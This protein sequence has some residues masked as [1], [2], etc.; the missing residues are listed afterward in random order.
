MTSFR[1][2]MAVAAGALATL[3]TY[4]LR[5]NE[6]FAAEW[7]PTSQLEMIISAKAGSGL[8]NT[9]RTVQALLQEAKLVPSPIIALNKPGGTYAVAFGY[10]D[11][12]PGD[13]HRLLVQ[14][15]SSLAAFITG[16]LKFNYFDLTPIA[17]LL[18]EPVALV[19][20]PDSPI[21][22]A[23]DLVARLKKDPGAVTIAIPGARGNAFHITAALLARTASI[24]PN[25]L[26]I[27]VY[28]SSGD[29]M[30]QVM[31]GH[32]D[33]FLVT[34]A[35][36]KS[37]LEAKKIRMVGMS[38]SKRLDGILAT[39]PT[40]KEQGF[41][42]QLSLWRGVLGAKGLSP[43]QVAYWDEIFGRMAHSKEW[44]QAADRNGWVSD[45]KNSKETKEYLKA[46]HDVLKSVLTEL[47]MVK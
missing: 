33:T 45:Y 43:A 37:L 13:G 36:F 32:V 39:V 40:F 16:E 27:V 35:N 42:I 22:D 3:T 26:M 9:A 17:N 34:P 11:R 44:R 4:G 25:K 20:R 19:V 12:F 1:F 6:A 24:D 46:E 2:L 18:N 15:S 10:F 23:Q 8:D 30:M 28:T 29:G 38:S 14:T 7:K 21:K 5:H 47:G 31:G 41:D